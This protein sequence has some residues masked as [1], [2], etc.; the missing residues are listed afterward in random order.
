MQICIAGIRQGFMYWLVTNRQVG[1]VSELSDWFSKYACTEIYPT[2][3][4]STYPLQKSGER[5]DQTAIPVKRCDKRGNSGNCAYKGLRSKTT[6]Y[7]P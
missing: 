2:D 1:A 7:S 3:G 6:I 5:S 4:H